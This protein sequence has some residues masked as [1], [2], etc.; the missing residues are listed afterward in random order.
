MPKSPIIAL[1]SLIALSLT[2]ASTAHASDVLKAQLPDGSSETPTVSET[3]FADIAK[4]TS[5]D[6]MSPGLTEAIAKVEDLPV[7]EFLNIYEWN[8]DTRLLVVHA[9]GD[10]EAIFQALQDVLP[11]GSFELTIDP[12]SVSELSAAADNIARQHTID[13]IP[14]AHAGPRADGTGIE[15]GVVADASQRAIVRTE[16]A[17]NTD[18]PVTVVEAPE[19]IAVDRQYQAQPYWGGAY[20]Q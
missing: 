19:I 15:V 16:L 11:K 6:G 18:Y 4:D 10:R 12:Y 20:I 2:V 5:S 17:I 8:H 7:R 14:I 1:L 13:G 9:F 3:L